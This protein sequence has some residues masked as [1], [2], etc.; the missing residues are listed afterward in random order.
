MIIFSIKKKCFIYFYYALIFFFKNAFFQIY[1]RT[2]LVQDRKRNIFFF[3]F[4][5]DND[6]ER[7]N[8]ARFSF[9]RLLNT[10]KFRQY[11]FFLIEKTNGV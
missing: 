3:H 2:Q 5:I 10:G 7:M 8:Q 6:S 11:F 1:P 4:H 9:C